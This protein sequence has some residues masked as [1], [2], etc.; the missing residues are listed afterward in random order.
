MLTIVTYPKSSLHQPS[1]TVT[2][3]DAALAELAVEMNATMIREKGIGLAAPQIGHNIRLIVV[4]IDPSNVEPAN[5]GYR[6]YV[7]PK[8]TFYS[9][10]TTNSEEG[11]LSVPGVYGYVTRHAKIRYQYHDL[12]GKKH[13]GKA[14][15]M[16]AIILQHEIGHINGQL[17]IDI[18]AR[19]THGAA[20]LEKMA[21]TEPT[22]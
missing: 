16:E 4:K 8:I 10:R 6:A 1:D 15:G 12:D 19:V 21:K 20:T 13:T 2:V 18:M 3:F 22:L 11:C 17:I 5:D 9:E 7:N 14:R